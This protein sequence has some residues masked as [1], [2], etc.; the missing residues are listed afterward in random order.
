[1]GPGQLVWPADQILFVVRAAGEGTV[2]LRL[3]I[4]NHVCLLKSSFKFL[5]FSYVIFSGFA[6]LGVLL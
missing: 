6:T 5:L 2:E 4:K 3:K 1:M